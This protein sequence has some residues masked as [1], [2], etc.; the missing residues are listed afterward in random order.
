MGR[1]GSWKPR[2]YVDISPPV[3]FDVNIKVLLKIKVLL[4]LDCEKES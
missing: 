4:T 3:N 1:K 2:G